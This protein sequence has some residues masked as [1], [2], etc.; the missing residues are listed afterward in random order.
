MVMTCSLD[1]D[2]NWT[3]R[4]DPRYPATDGG[5]RQGKDSTL[6][7]FPQVLREH[8]PLSWFVPGRWDLY[9]FADG[10]SLTMVTSEGSFRPSSPSVLIPPF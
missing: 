2:Q 1:G 8:Q 4:P 6:R 3:P 10:L 5:G 7:S 9:R